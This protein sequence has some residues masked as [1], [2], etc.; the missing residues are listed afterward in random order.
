MN[1][2][3]FILV[4]GCAQTLVPP[5]VLPIVSSL[6]WPDILKEIGTIHWGRLMSLY[7]YMA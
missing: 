7:A 6:I 1:R 4:R 2:L 3:H 5:T